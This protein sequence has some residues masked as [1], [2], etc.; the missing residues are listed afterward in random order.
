MLILQSV[1]Y[2]TSIR[3]TSAHHKYT[4]SCVSYWP[5]S[6]LQE[7]DADGSPELA[8]TAKAKGSEGQ[9]L[10]LLALQQQGTLQWISS[11]PPVPTS[12]E[13]LARKGLFPR[14]RQRVAWP[15]KST[16]YTYYIFV[17]MFA[18]MCFI[19]RQVYIICSYGGMHVWLWAFRTS[20]FPVEAHACIRTI[21]IIIPESIKHYTC[22]FLSL[23]ILLIYLFAF[24]MC[25]RRTSSWQPAPKE[26]HNARCWADML[27]LFRDAVAK[28]AQ[29]GWE[30]G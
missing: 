14:L 24:F 12:N 20:F 3:S 29:G 16:Q 26:F 2:N 1:L 27:R 15:P 10:S 28:C 6:T 22:S 13:A 21:A 11:Q 4:D 18:A 9:F 7:I 30:H 19:L 5:R 17:G 23:F 25:K 8:A